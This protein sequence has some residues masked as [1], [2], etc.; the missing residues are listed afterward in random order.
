MVFV[1][2]GLIDLTALL[3]NS[4]VG[5]LLTETVAS[6]LL[7]SNRFRYDFRN[8][9]DRFVLQNRLLS[10]VSDFRK[11]N[12]YSSDRA[13]E[14]CDITWREETLRHILDLSF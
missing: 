14:L 8:R 12:Q 4:P 6:Q 5:L 2:R 7:K 11:V 13:L 10:P 9:L 3:D 1:K